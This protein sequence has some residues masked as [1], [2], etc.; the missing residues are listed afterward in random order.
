MAWAN[1]H[2][3]KDV[4]ELDGDYA[5]V[6]RHFVRRRESDLRNTRRTMSVLLHHASIADAIC[7]HRNSFVLE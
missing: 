3:K 5:R 1:A 7:Q 4:V 2:L 6:G